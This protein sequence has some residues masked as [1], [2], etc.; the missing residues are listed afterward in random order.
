MLAVTLSRRRIG[1]SAIALALLGAATLAPK[2][3]PQLP[4]ALPAA[5]PSSSLM[6]ATRPLA[7][8][9]NRGQWDAQAQFLAR[10]PGV[11]TWVTERGVVYDFHRVEAEVGSGKSKVESR[12]PS[13][14]ISSQ[15]SSINN[16]KNQESRIK[17]SRRGHI[18]RMEFVGGKPSPVR[19]EGE[20]EARY[21]YF[22]G[23]QESKWA[24]DVPSF[25]EARSEQIYDG[26]EARWYFDQGR[27][28][29]D[30]IVAPGADPQKIQMRF[31]GT[32]GVSTDGRSLKLATSMG[33][34]E[35]RGLFAYQKSAGKLQQVACSFRAEGSTVRFAVGD[36]DRTKPLV[37]DPLLW[38]TLFGGDNNYEAPV[39]ITLDG[40]GKP[41]V[42]GATIAGDFPVTVGAYDT[43][44]NGGEDIFVAR[45]NA[46]GTAIEFGTYLGG[47]YVDTVAGVRIDGAG[48][49]C[50]A[51]STR[52]GNFPFT[53]GAF[54]TVNWNGDGFIVKFNPS[55][56]ALVFSTFLGGTGW[57]QIFGLDMGADG[58]PLVVG[59]TGSL[60]F[61]TTPNDFDATNNG[62][63]DGFAA[64][65]SADGATMVYGTY[66]GGS[67][68]DYAWSCALTPSG[69][70]VVCGRTSSSDLPIPV[71]SPDT[72]LGGGSSD[73]FVAKFSADGSL[74]LGASYVGGIYSDAPNGVALDISGGAYVLSA[75]DSPDMP[76]TPGAYQAANNGA[77]ETHIAHYNS[78]ITSVLHATYL[79]SSGSDEPEAIAVDSWGNAIVFGR[80]GSATFPTTAG[81]FDRTHGGS[82]DAFLTKLSPDLSAIR[83]ST[84]LGGSDLDNGYA[85]KIDSANNTIAGGYTASNDFPT[86]P[87]AIKS[88]QVGGDAFLAKVAT[89][90]ALLN[91]SLPRNTS[92]GGFYL[93]LT[94]NLNQIAAPTGT[95]VTLSTNTPG[96]VLIPASTKVPAGKKSKTL[97]I[98]TETVKVNTP[99]QITATCNGVS[100]TLSVTLR[101]GGLL[102]VK[103]SPTSLTSFSLGSGNVLLSAPAP[104]DGRRVELDSSKSTLLYVPSTVDVEYGEDGAVFP[105]FAG[106][107]ASSANVTVT[108]RLG[109]MQK[110]ATIT[111]KP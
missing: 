68:G 73:G 34:I 24:S 56:S 109:S 75:T 69:E 51:G 36:Y 10:S 59:S 91:A 22:L 89:A 64:K 76:V 26:V 8:I 54:D 79:G 17:N 104:I 44:Y 5:T 84:F 110:T 83:Y 106:T 85:L 9:E 100:K 102:S 94:L 20:L 7:F 15:Q 86:T 58:Q 90:P 4:A 2:S 72:S 67:S 35:H 28:R 55:G 60:D 63:Y 96:K 39:S 48:N 65:L 14:P 45:F 38:S 50:V 1:T 12:E 98:R 81:A 61:P 66:F 108:A 103:L 87:G 57:D 53:A 93:Q 95:S 25:A 49:I 37:I 11:D 41:V 82:M 92:V 3:P 97:G 70:A 74:L 6:R 16:P 32:Q 101:P 40:S 33:E 47:D 80:T 18:V 105:T 19:G 62:D 77:F 29:Y 78:T 46:T 23:N 52:S 21:N 43:T 13:S 99:V 107:I 42:C 111:L 27:P 71:G 31:Q 88:T 30:L